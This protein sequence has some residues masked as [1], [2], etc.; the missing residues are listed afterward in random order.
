MELT[1]VGNGL[2]FRASGLVL[3]HS[4][5]FSTC[6]EKPAG[7]TIHRMVRLSHRIQL[8][9]QT[10]TIMAQKISKV[11]LKLSNGRIVVVLDIESKK[12]T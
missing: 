1:K 6:D 2:V 12:R 9:R 3:A 8:L 5:V 10:K 4:A 7:R 11:Q